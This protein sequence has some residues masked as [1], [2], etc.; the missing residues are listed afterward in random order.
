MWVVQHGRG[1]CKQV[2]LTGLDSCWDQVSED[3]SATQ[4]VETLA[5]AMLAAKE[6]YGTHGSANFRLPEKLTLLH[7]CWAPGLRDHTSLLGC[8]TAHLH[9][10]PVPSVLQGRQC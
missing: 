6:A 7:K 3:T 4:A 10:F 2:C 1:V 5:G 8:T 9:R